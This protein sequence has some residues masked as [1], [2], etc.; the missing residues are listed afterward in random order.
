MSAVT[1]TPETVLSDSLTNVRRVTGADWGLLLIRVMV[2][3]VFLFHG[4][5]K[6]FGGH[7]Q[8]AGFLAMLGIPLPGLNAWVAGI[9]E[10][11][12][13]VALITGFGLRVMAVPLVATMLV[14]SF[15]AHGQA[16]SI[17][18]GGMEYALTLG[19]VVAGLALTGA[20]RLSLGA[21]VRR[22]G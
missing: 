7:D 8:F 18:S 15:V 20:G 1:T 4:L 17:Q 10:V 5:P 11:V 14:A 9:T 22:A 21:L 2:G 16:F 6:L 12:G 3:V 19:A 13:G